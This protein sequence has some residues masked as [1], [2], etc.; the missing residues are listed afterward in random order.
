MSRKRS[1]SGRLMRRD[2]GKWGNGMG[3]K[4][5]RCAKIDEGVERDTGVAEAF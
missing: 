3:E 2:G 1:E 4:E 5:R